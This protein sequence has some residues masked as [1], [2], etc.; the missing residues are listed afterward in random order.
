[1]RACI[2]MSVGVAA[3]TA[4]GPEPAPASSPNEA[5]GP[6]RQLWGRVH[7]VADHNRGMPNIAVST[8]RDATTTDILG[9][10]RVAASTSQTLFFV[11]TEETPWTP[12]AVHIPAYPEDTPIWAGLL[13][14]EDTERMLAIAATTSQVSP[15]FLPEAAYLAVQV[16][17]PNKVDRVT[18]DHADVRVYD[19]SGALLPDAYYAQYNETLSTCLPV[20]G[21]QGVA[22]A[23]PECNGLAAFPEV[24]AG[25]ELEVEVEVFDGQTCARAAEEVLTGEGAPTA[26][27]RFVAE[28]GHLNVVNMLC[29]HPN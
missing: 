22:R 2:L 26:S 8:D 7:D 12:V 13:P 9:N 15:S 25:V 6:A 19:P 28:P 14:L 18:L 24:P 27:F 29:H 3:C 4:Q 16:H 10:F 23:L 1:M 21:E 17:L 5:F 20:R 11:H